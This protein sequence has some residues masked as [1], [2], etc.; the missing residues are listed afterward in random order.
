MS[1]QRL[2]QL[3]GKNNE[4]IYTSLRRQ[5]FHDATYCLRCL[6]IILGDG[7]ICDGQP[8]AL[9][10]MSGEQDLFVLSFSSFEDDK[11]AMQA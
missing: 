5:V 4:H 6:S 9:E 11:R 8:L 1:S 3:K 10:Q 2:D 7:P